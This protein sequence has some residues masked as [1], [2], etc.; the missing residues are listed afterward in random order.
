M[1]V[2]CPGQEVDDGSHEPR[3]G[4]LDPF[5]FSQF[6]QLPFVNCSWAVYLTCPRGITA[7]TRSWTGMNSWSSCTCKFA[8]RMG[9]LIRR[10]KGQR[11]WTIFPPKLYPICACFKD[12]E[13]EDEIKQQKERWV[14]AEGCLDGT[15]VTS[16][17]EA[18]YIF[19]LC[20]LYDNPEMGVVM[21][22][23]HHAHFFCR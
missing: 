20:N 19:I 8:D 3:A 2:P 13:G 9:A 15:Q 6:S 23:H 5:V 4:V 17:C 12:V 21:R 22:L 16:V 18:L 1:W 14:V 10:Q 7:V 11:T